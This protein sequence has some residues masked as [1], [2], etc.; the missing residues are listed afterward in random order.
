MKIKMIGTG[1]ISSNRNSATAL[2]DDEILM[3]IPNGSVKA[4]KNQGIEI[5]KIDYIFI[6]H[7][8]GDHYFDIPFIFLNYKFNKR[9]KKIN[10]V[11]PKGIKDKVKMIC[12]MAFLSLFDE[13][14]SILE[15]IEVEDKKVIDF[16]SFKV[17]V[18]KTVHSDNLE[19]YGYIITKENKI[20]G[21]TGDT[22][23]CGAT[24]YITSN[25][26]I[27]IVD[28]AMIIG[29]ESHMGIDNIKELAINSKRIIPTHMID[30]TYNE[31][32]KSNIDNVLVLND[33]ESIEEI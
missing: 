14:S 25:T 22:T 26:D 15:F 21:Y 11:G 10:I 24:K 28:M 20:I 27:C 5:N 12:D 19:S 33:G 13:M 32:K 4:M 31:I 23:L 3:D 7:F 8:H 6:T 9:E 30:N 2:I 18:I 17:E 29:N 1:S 16:E